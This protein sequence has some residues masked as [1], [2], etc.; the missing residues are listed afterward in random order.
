[1]PPGR[2]EFEDFMDDYGP[3]TEPLRI[4]V[5]VE[6]AESSIHVD[7]TGTSPQVRAAINCPFNF[8]YA[9]TLYGI[10]ALTSPFV[11]ENEGTR[12]PI[13]VSA[14]EG[15]FVNPTPPSPSGARAIAAMRIVDAV[16]GAMAK[17]LPQRGLAAPSHFCNV[18]YGGRN[19]STGEAYIGYEMLL[20]GFGARPDK[21]GEDGLV[22][23]INCTNIP[24][25]VQEATNPVLIERLEYITD[26]AGVGKFRGGTGIRRDIRI[27]DDLAFTTIGDRF[28]F[29]PWGLWGGKSGATGSAQLIRDGVSQ[30]L[31][32]KGTFEVRAGD[33]F[34]S[35]VSGAGGFGD[36]LTR[37]PEA[38][39]KDVLDGLVSAQAAIEQHGVSID[40]AHERVDEEKTRALRKARHLQTNSRVAGGKE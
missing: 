1:V 27:L 24:V 21:D 36:A 10:R 37:D 8:T 9:W 19:R 11:P 40:L 28:K 18:T 3:G 17:A 20:G 35:C 7:F 2:Y 29:P 5:A 15:C 16:M 34:I 14:P 32:S 30:T 23:S 4:S 31:G 25:E 12:R 39:L 22:A 26:S 6:V 38:V 13:S 33:L